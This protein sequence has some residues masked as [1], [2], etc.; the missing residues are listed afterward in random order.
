MRI[1]ACF[2][3]GLV[4]AGC[5]T[6]EK[7]SALVPG[8]AGPVI[9]SRTDLGTPTDASHAMD[10]GLAI[11]FGVA[12]AALDARLDAGADAASDAS[13]DAQID[14]GSDLG[15]T[16]FCDRRTEDGSSIGDACGV[17]GECAPGYT[18]ILYGT[19]DTNCQIPC[20]AECGG[21]DCPIGYFC[22]EQPLFGSA[23]T[24]FLCSTF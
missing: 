3:F 11:D 14:S 8:D 10:E 23:G 9:V 22:F 17:S 13:R 1:A 15:G 6:P 2:Y 21:V 7:F 19:G 16:G 24:A 4:V 12:D 20:A 5:A 18:C